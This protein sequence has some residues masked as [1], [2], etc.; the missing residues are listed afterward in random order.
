MENSLQYFY[1]NLSNIKLPLKKNIS[2][3]NLSILKSNIFPKLIL[4]KRKSNYKFSNKNLLRTS[5]QDRK[6]FEQNLF[7][8]TFILKNQISNSNNSK[9]NDRTSS[10]NESK[11]KHHSYIESSTNFPKKKSI[12][13]KN[14]ENN[15]SQKK[16]NGEKWKI[17]SKLSKILNKSKSIQPKYKRF[18]ETENNQ[19][20]I[21][22]KLDIGNNHKN[23][24]TKDKDIII[25]KDEFNSKKEI[26]KL[27]GK[28]NYLI[29]KNKILENE[30]NENNQRI[31]ILEK[32]IDKLIDYIKINEISNLKNKINSLENNVN[33]LKSENE[34]LKKEIDKK[35]KIFLGSDITK[36]EK[37]NKSIGKKKSNEGID[38]KEESL[39]YDSK[40]KYNL[41]ESDIQRIKLISIDPDN[42]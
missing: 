37:I 1:T 14:N 33:H 13:F 26:E 27:K 7:Q 6:S 11:T 4:D 10:T 20:V 16:K 39:F 9:S 29:K 15:F 24:L 12:Y 17:Q 41:N 38:N 21:F 8:S 3:N 34:K 18:S 25:E 36:I 19:K 28:V 42:I 5:L 32:K 40:I 30:K 22:N 35:N 31:D 2:I 23:H